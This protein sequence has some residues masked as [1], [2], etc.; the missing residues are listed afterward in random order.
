MRY[1]VSSLTAAVV[2]V[3]V[4][5]LASAVTLTAKM[6]KINTQKANELIEERDGE[7]DFMILDVRTPEEFA[8]GHVENAV[9]LDF[10]EDAFPDELESLDR[11]KTYLVYCRSGSRSGSTFK[12]MKKLGFQHVY[13]VEGGI[14]RW[15]ESYP[16]VK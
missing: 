15:S 10:Y 7:P 1:R 6:K 14:N 12:M 4:F 16:V 3:L 9:N 5:V 13:N 11:D 2:L 8:E